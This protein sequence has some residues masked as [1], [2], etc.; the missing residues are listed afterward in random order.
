MTFHVLKQ[1]S[2]T[3]QTLMG[4]LAV[5]EQ[6]HS[7]LLAHLEPE[8]GRHC[9]VAK[10]EKNCL[11]VIVENGNWATQLR[12]QVPD[13]MAKLRLQPGFENLGGIICKT[14][15]SLQ[16]M[17]PQKKQKRMVKKLSAETAAQILEN[18]QLIQDPKLRKILERI[19]GNCA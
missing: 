18:A 15:P 11:F 17:D 8:L 13:L 9:Q 12:F 10:F 5:L 6:I 3:L 2:K 14:R 4:K 16:M 7:L 19:A 1:D